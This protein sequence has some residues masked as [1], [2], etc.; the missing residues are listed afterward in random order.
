MAPA[1]TVK[2]RRNDLDWVRIFAVLLL[3]PFHTARIFDIFETF[4]VK[5]RV[6]SPGLSYAVVGFLNKWQMP[7][8]FLLAGASTWYALNFRS[9]GRYMAERL[10]RLMIPFVFGTLVVVPPQM[11]F[12]LLHRGVTPG[13]YPAYYPTFF[14]LRPPGM[15]DYTGVGF[16]WGHLWFILNL[17]FMSL[18]ALP[19][20]LALKTK[21]GR[22]VTAG[23]AGFL[24]RG[25]AILL[26]ALPFPFVQFLL[27][28]IDGKP[29]FVHLMVFVFGFLLMSDERYRRAL[30]RN[31]FLALTLGLVCAC[32]DLA[33]KLFG[34]RFADFSP[35]SIALSLANGFDTW[36]WL[37]AILGFGR[38][39]LNVDN[40]ALR[41]AREGAYPFYVLHQSV[42]VAIGYYVV[43]MNA[44][45]LLK[46]FIIAAGSL[47]GT[48]VLYD[49]MVR[50]TNAARFLFGM[51]RLPS[52]PR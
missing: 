18:A 16:T 2:E 39:H 10:K 11:Y 22:R 14:R 36:F 42:I 7:L 50:R 49:L 34:V 4:Y 23:I 6:L 21:A 40:R 28:E 3:I 5:N 20:F 17:F 35:P 26:L 51:K 31:R 45:A 19:L 29:V 15:P 24:E 30:D 47:A 43:R 8:L 52:K 38:R 12:A 46:Y 41:Y 1:D 32:A 48:I 44:G 37:A 13:S 27:P 33:V 9:G 25:P